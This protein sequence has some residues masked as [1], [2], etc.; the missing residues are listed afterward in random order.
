MGLLLKDYSSIPIV[1]VGAR[2][3]VYEEDKAVL[4]S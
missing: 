2:L 3:L 1:A 4:V